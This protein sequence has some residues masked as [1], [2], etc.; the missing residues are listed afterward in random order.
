MVWGFGSF[1]L[2]DI[3]GKSPT[4]PLYHKGGGGGQFASA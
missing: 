1:H 2:H 3:W 4:A